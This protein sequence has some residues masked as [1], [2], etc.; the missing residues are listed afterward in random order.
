MGGRSVNTYEEKYAKTK[1]KQLVLWKEM[2]HRVFGENQNDLIKIT[3]RNQII[4]IL[5]AVGTD[6]AD[7]HTFLPTSGGLDLHGATASH[8]EGRIELTFEGRTTYIVN[9]DSL[10]F[11]QVG[12]DPEWWYFRLNTKPFKA[13]GVYEETTSVEQVFESELDKEVSWSMSYYGEEVLELEAGV[14]VDYAVREIGHLGYDEYGN[15]IP[16]PDSARTVHRGINGGSYAIFSKYALYNR[17]SSTYDARHNKV[18]DDEFR[19]YINNIVNS[20][21]KK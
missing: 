1:E 9:P 11:H 4:E 15:S 14:Y 18:S 12:E 2:V 3:D 17:V 5:N 16:L 13:S 20:L 19:V 7:N 6:E 21:N 10:T 8:E